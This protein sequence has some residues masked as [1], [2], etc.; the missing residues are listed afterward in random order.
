MSAAGCNFATKLRTCARG[1]LWFW[2]IFNLALPVGP[3]GEALAQSYRAGAQKY[4]KGDIQGAEA[5]LTRAIGSTK[6]PKELG[7]VYKLLGISQFMLNKKPAARESFRRA[8]A[9]DPGT[10]ISADEVLDESVIPYFDAVRKE[11]AKAPPA[12]TARNEQPAPQRTSKFG[13]QTNT[14]SIMVNS[15]AAGA[16]VTVDGIL[17]GAVGQVIETDPGTVTIILKAKGYRSKEFRIN[18]KEN[19]QNQYVLNLKPLSREAAPPPAAVAESNAEKIDPRTGRKSTRKRKEVEVDL[20]GEDA[21]AGRGRQLPPGAPPVPAP[22]PTPSVSGQDLV[23]EFDQDVKGRRGRQ[24]AAVPPVAQ[25]VQPPPPQGFQ[26]QQPPAGLT[27]QQQQQAY[28]YQQQQLQQQYLQ[29]QQQ[30]QQQGQQPQGGYQGYPPQYYGQQQNLPPQAGQAFQT[31]PAGPQQ[32]LPPSAP[33]QFNQPPPVPTERSDNLD[34]ED[35]GTGGR[36]GKR[37]K[38]KSK[39][40]RPSTF[41][42]LLPFGIGQYANGSGALGALFTIGELGS[43]YFFTVSRENQKKAFATAQ[44]FINEPPPTDPAAA[45]DDAQAKEDFAADTEKYINAQKTNERLG[46]LGFLGLWGAGGLEAYLSAVSKSSSRSRSAVDPADSSRW[47][48]ISGHYTADSF[49]A[50][51]EVDTGPA[52]DSYW[53]WGAGVLSHDAGEQA[54][55][56]L[57]VQWQWHF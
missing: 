51:D 13:K 46:L 30:Q 39:S 35:F 17:A 54:G 25:P 2:L 12:R 23:S 42:L 53:Q 34:D 52:M 18:V 27:P 38:S 14:T 10:R 19:R 36:S 47:A 26:K 48:D 40:S 1:A 44:D 11:A 57:G 49:A 41:V 16:T 20:F 6:D 15:N 50:N 29:Q 5:A 37:K 33:Q 45:A 56:G 55:L 32:Q 22:A 24:P 43:L 21:D 31:Q 9:S 4:A 7:K 28:L 3:L 8:L